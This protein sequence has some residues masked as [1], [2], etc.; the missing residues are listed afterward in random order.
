MSHSE[1]IINAESAG[2]LDGLFRAR[3]QRSPNK[4]AYRQFN[5]S[6]ALWEDFSWQEV[7]EQVARWQ[8][9]LSKTQLQSGDRVA[10]LLR[11][12]V[13]W[14]VAE[15]AAMGMGMVIVPLY[16][17]DRPENIAF[18]LND[19]ATQMLIAN[20]AMWRR[21]KSACGEVESLIDVIIVPVDSEVKDIEENEKVHIAANWLTDKTGELQ[22]HDRQSDE[23]AT[24]V[25]TSGTTGR[26]KGVMLSHNNILSISNSILISFEIYT[27]DLFLSFL[28]LSHTFERTVGHFMPMMAGASVGYSRSVALLADDMQQIKPTVMVAVPRIFERIH[29]RMQQQLSKKS[30]IARALFNLTVT[31][32]WWKFNRQ[33]GR[34]SWLKPLIY[35]PLLTILSPLVI[36]TFC[37]RLGGRM[38]LTV[39]G[40]APLPLPVARVM[41]GLGLKLTQG[42]GLTE[43]SPVICSNPIDD[44]DP[45]SVGVTLK[46]I[47]ARIGE[48]DELQVKTPGMMMGY[49]NNHAATS[50]IIG[51]DGW[52]HTGDQ[53]RIENHHIYITGRLKDI[54]IL[55]NGEK[56]PPTDMESAIVVESLFEQ[57]LVVGEGQSFLSALIVLNNDEWIKLANQFVID[58]YKKESLNEPRIHS[59]IIGV[60]RKALNEFPSYAKIRR[61]SL[62]LE[63]W[64]VDNNLMTPTLKIKRNKVIEQNADNIKNIYS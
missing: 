52:V 39:S 16:C 49:W 5:K 15:Q 40:G 51:A 4:I 41:I 60:L 24:I 28:P 42:Y 62:S 26:P 20:D 37:Q 11:N 3:V 56:V 27:D 2:T 12:G 21:V 63:Q 23:L 43:T 55:S 10:L 17:D 31:L 45:A 9:A 19:S 57:V 18:I 44:N 1:D 35:A 30:F 46:G 61:V 36:K 38:R 32:G 47:E 6:S 34:G 29:T 53:A 59:H 13:D 22:S 25:Y 58:P 14:V 54:L 7:G 48:N 33:Q 8:Q 64:T 50:E